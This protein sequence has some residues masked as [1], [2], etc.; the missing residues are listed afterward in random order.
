MTIVVTSEKLR[1]VRGAINATLNKVLPEKVQVQQYPDIRPLK[2]FAVRDEIRFALMAADDLQE[3]AE[4]DRGNR[5]PVVPLHAIAR[6]DRPAAW[7]GWYERWQK[8]A[9]D[10]YEL[11]NA[12]ATFFWGVPN[13]PAKQQVLRAEWDSDAKASAGSAQPHWQ[14]D[15]TFRWTGAAIAEVV[16]TIP[17]TT[18]LVEESAE[19]LEEPALLEYGAST[20][21]ELSLSKM[22]LSMAGWRNGNT[23]DTWWKLSLPQQPAVFAEWLER[24]I[25]HAA[26]QFRLFAAKSVA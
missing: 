10:K 6:F 23:A 19:E 1:A 4:R 21:H 12:S 8:S 16:D 15:P 9:S 17:V 20:A 24:T 2:L 14:F 22:H 7:I 5:V 25:T 11:L 26:D 3:F 13:R 18:E